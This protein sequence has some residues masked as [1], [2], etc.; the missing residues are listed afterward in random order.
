M[1]DLYLKGRK[2]AG[3]GTFTHTANAHPKMSIW[4]RITT[5]KPLFQKKKEARGKIKEEMNPEGEYFF[6]QLVM[7]CISPSDGHL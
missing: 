4:K 6:T 5:A 7:E 2:E 1:A 3:K